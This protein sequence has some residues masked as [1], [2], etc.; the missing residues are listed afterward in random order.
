MIGFVGSLKPWHGLEDLVRAFRRLHRSWKGYRL[1]VVGDGPMR[2]EI[3]RQVSAWGLEAAVTFTGPAAHDEVPRWIARMDVA[4]APYPK[5]SPTYFSP[6]KIFEYMAAGIPVVAS[7]VGQIGEFLVHRRSAML[8]EPGSVADLVAC[9]EEL[10]RRP[11]L[12]ARLAREARSRLVRNW[13][14][15]RNAARV[16]ALVRSVARSA[17]KHDEAA[18]PREAAESPRVRQAPLSPRR[19][20]AP[21]RSSRTARR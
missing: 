21:K 11:A 7:R 17:P 8:H 6:I 19:R 20:S 18:A 9:V 14:W 10:R 15:N 13:T 3:E 16:L 1:V 5:D 4:V 2:E 12:A